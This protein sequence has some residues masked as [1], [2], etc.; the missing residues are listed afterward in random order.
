MELNQFLFCAG[1][2]N[3]VIHQCNGF[4]ARLGLL[5]FSHLNEFEQRPPPL[6]PME[7]WLHD[8]WLW[9]TTLN[10]ILYGSST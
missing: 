4:G 9:K 10:T 1:V 7:I 2:F 6:L 8:D 5:N 3:R